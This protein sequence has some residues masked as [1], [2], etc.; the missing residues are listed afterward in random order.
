MKRISLLAIVCIAAFS[1]SGCGDN[2]AVSGVKENELVMWLVGSEVQAQSVIQLGERYT[3]TTGVKIRVETISWGDAHSKYLT[4]IAGGVSPD[5]GTMGLTWGTEFG[6]LGTMVDLRKEFSDDINEI[7]KKVFPGMWGSVVCKGSVYGIPFDM[8]E[9]ILYYRNDIVETPPKTWEELTTLLVELEKDGKGM[10]FD[11]GSMSWIGYSC[12]LWQAGGDYCNDDYTRSM[13]D[14][15]EA[16]D[17]LKFFSELYTKYNVPKT[18]I[19]LEQ[20]MRTGDFPLAISG[21]W[22]IQGLTL[23]A[24]E[25]KD[26][27]SIAPLPWGPAGKRT[28]FIGGR[29][30]GIFSRSKQKEKAWD[31]IKFLFTP[32]S[33]GKL[34]QDALVKQDAYLPP[35]FSAWDNLNMDRKFKSALIRQARDAKGPPPIVNWDTCTK[36]ID[37]AIQKVIL[38]GADPKTELSAANKKIDKLLQQ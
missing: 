38:R 19:P 17:A 15:P 34:Y 29:V 21:N 32:E 23:G 3:G 20:G 27:W 33:Q 22:K 5:I 10:I 37:E 1:L 14:T 2:G 31:F 16:I 11:W 30:M 25:L 26:K 9:Q 6:A 18:R 35:N 4:S 13:I 36:H 7:K 24:P 28:A 8:T 12:F